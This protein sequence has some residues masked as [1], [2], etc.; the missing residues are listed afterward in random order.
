LSIVRYKDLDGDGYGNKLQVI[1][2]CEKPDD[3]WV[4]DNTDCNDENEY[5]HPGADDICKDGIDQDCSGSD[6]EL[7]CDDPQV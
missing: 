2:S 6:S 1:I 4:I 3:S 5:I 7:S